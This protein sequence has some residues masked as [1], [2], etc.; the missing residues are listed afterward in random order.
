[1]NGYKDIQPVSNDIINRLG[2]NSEVAKMV[3]VSIAAISYWRKSGIPPLR[4]IQLKSLKPEA[5]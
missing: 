5:F 4:L 2:S 1:M 3:G